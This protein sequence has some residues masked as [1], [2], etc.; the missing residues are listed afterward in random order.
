REI[1]VVELV[2]LIADAGQDMRG[3]SDKVAAIRRARPDARVAGLWAVR[4]THRNRALIAELGPLIDARFP[5]H[6]GAWLK[7]LH[8]PRT[9]MPSDDGLVWARVD[10]SGLVGRRAG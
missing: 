6:S 4:A 1:A 5:A 3:L 10:G 2:D 9:R 8:D 7:A